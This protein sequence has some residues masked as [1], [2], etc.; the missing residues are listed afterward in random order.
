MRRIAIGFAAVVA[1]L[2]GPGCRST[3]T[4]GA[5]SPSGPAAGSFPAPASSVRVAAAGAMD[6]LAIRNVDAGNGAGV[7]SGTTRD[8]RPVRVALRPGVRSTLAAVEVGRGGDPALA[9]ALFER[10]GVRLGTRPPETSS[11]RGSRSIRS[12][13]GSDAVPDS[14]MLRDQAEA[15]YR[16]SPAP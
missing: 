4:L 1:G 11:G 5:A 6:D 15:G 3:G 14:V 8:G 13:L 10:I 9:H 2:L 16:D 7:V 12:W